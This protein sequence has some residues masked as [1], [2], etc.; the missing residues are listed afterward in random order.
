MNAKIW[1][2]IIGAAAI[3]LGAW[4]AFGTKDETVESLVS[5]ENAILLQDQQPADETVVSYV[6]L[7]QPGYVT[8]HA[9]DDSGEKAFVGS[10]ELLAAGEHKNVRVRH[11]TGAVIKGTITASVV[12]DDGDGAYSAETDA[13]VL[14]SDDSMM[15]EDAELTLDLSDEA[16]AALLDEAGYDV[17]VEAAAEEQA[18]AEGDASGDMPEEETPAM[19][20][21]EVS[22]GASGTV[23]VGADLDPDT[24]P[25]VQ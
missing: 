5:D 7:S 16:L 13:E 25:S 21:S 12:A 18:E 20:E 2:V 4:Y 15:S 17:A 24:D 14:V 1:I 23:E 11:S 10:S 19:E 8:V 3:G 9:T 6:K 22:G